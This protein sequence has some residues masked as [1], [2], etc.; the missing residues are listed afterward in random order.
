MSN[1]RTWPGWY[2]VYQKSRRARGNQAARQ[3]LAGPA[4]LL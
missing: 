2:V 3:P 1:R 4:P